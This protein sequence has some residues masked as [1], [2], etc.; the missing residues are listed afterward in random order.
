VYILVVIVLGRGVDTAI[1]VP[2][3]LQF[4]AYEVTVSVV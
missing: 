3:I 2:T 4:A 1:G